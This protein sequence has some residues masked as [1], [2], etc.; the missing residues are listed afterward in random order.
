VPKRPC[1]SGR[2]T[3][4]AVWRA[5]RPVVRLGAI[6]ITYRSPTRAIATI[7]GVVAGLLM[8]AVISGLWLPLGPLGG[9]AALG[10]MASALRVLRLDPA[11]PGH[12]GR[13][14]AGGS[15][16]REPRR[17]GPHRPTGTVSL[18]CPVEPGRSL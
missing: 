6:V 17:P 8:G 16:V 11:C 7:A 10:W 9:A 2:R 5:Q 15:G 14:G 4:T 1:Q 13:P 3:A 18:P 12:G